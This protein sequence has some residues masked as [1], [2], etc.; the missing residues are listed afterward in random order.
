ME[1]Y[2]W[3]LSG[4][5]SEIILRATTT[6]EDVACEWNQAR[7][8]SQELLLQITEFGKTLIVRKYAVNGVV[9]CTYKAAAVFDSFIVSLSAWSET[10]GQSV[11]PVF[12]SPTVA[13]GLLDGTVHFM[14]VHAKE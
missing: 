7:H 10:P 6:F 4:P 8:G 2:A 13:V 11:A 12:S 1:T 3:K 5:E 14:E 9:H